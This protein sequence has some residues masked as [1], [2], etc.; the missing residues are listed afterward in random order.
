MSHL[1][2]ENIKIAISAILS[3]KMRSFLTALGIIIGVLAVTLMGTLISGLDRSFD[4]SMSFLGKDVL[5]VSKFEWF[6]DQDFWELRN[7]P[8]IKAEYTEALKEQGKYIIAASAERYRGSDM[9]FEEKN[10]SDVQ[11]MG[12]TPEY[13]QTS[14]TV[15]ENG[16]FFT[17]GEERS[18]S[19]VTVIGYDVADALFGD[20]DPVGQYVKVGSYKF[21]VVGVIKKQGK[22]LGLFSMDNQAIIPLETFQRLFSRR[23][24]SRLSV[25][26]D[27]SNIEEARYEVQSILRRLRGLRPDEPDNF[28]INQQEAFEQQY[29]AI[30][31]AIGGTGIF[32]T[33][34]S[35]VVGG[36]GI[37]NIMFVSV[38]ERTREIGIRKAIG[39][40]RNVILSQFL[41]EAVLICLI[42]GLIGLGLAFL[43]SFAINQFLPSTMPVSLAVFAVILSLAV[44]VISGLVPSY[45]AA[46]LDPIEALSYD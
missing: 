41:I 27:E 37:M 2:F 32:I 36:I 5:Y 38:K 22:F 3:S 42:G 30:K 40:K 28:A 24:F 33:V 14:N 46:K 11:T 19:R 20:D 12:T 35:L 9:S 13:M 15:I 10:I 18:G 8:D 4:N 23:G 16:R 43:L 29:N 1:F 17:N 31:L 44:G 6:G 7:R 34:L 25:K 26:V 21:R 45:R 39:A